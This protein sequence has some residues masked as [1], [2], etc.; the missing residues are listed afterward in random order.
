MA[1]EGK[2]IYFE[3]LD[4]IRFFAAMMIVALHSYEAWCGWYGELGILSGGTFKELTAIGKY[5][6]ELIRNFGLGVDI[7][8]LISGFLITYILLE[9]KKRTSTI[10][11]GKFMVRRSL[12]IW[13]LYFLLIGLAPLIVNWLGESEPN[14]L[15]NIFFLGNFN[16]IHTEQWAYPFAHFWTICIEEHFYLVWPFIIYAI[17]RKYLLSVFVSVIAISI[18]YRLYVTLTMERPWFELLLNTLS[19]IDVLVVGAM[20]A[21]FYSK[22]PFTFQLNRIV[23]ALLFAALIVS[24]S[25]ASVRH[26]DTLFLA[27]FKKYLY[28]GI[29][30]LLLLDYNFNPKFKHLLRP[31]SFL[32]YLGKISYGIYMYGNIL[33]AIILKKLMVHFDGANA[34][35]FFGLTFGITIIVS[36]ISYELFEKR[37]LKLNKRFR[38]VPTER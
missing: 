37:L 22:K 15:A 9:E 29:M 19:R 13:P 25:V 38:V 31:K 24:L 28:I 12:R 10:H 8:F 7:F 4:V 23:R 27:G 26:W 5:V 6:D 3:H 36:I 30:A 14:Y 33:L 35:M 16:I 34:Y 18:S 17:P 21:L 20:G 2:K 32:H 11:I 1:A